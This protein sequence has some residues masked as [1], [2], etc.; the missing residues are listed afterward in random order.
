MVE[1]LEILNLAPQGLGTVYV[2][3]PSCGRAKK[4]SISR[5]EDGSILYHCFR[6]TCPANRGGNI[7]PNGVR[8][9]A[10]VTPTA[11]F[12]RRPFDGD[13]VPLPPKRRR[14]LKEVLGLDDEHLETARIMWA[15]KEARVAY[16]IFDPMGVRDGWCLR[17]YD[18]DKPKALTQMEVA[19][20]SHSYYGAGT[21]PTVIVEDPLSGIRASRYLN[22]VAL[23][24][25]G[26]GA[27]AAI[28]IAANRPD[29]IFAL[30]R[31]ATAQAI[32]LVRRHRLLFNSSTVLTLPRDL[33]DFPEPE[34]AEFLGAIIDRR[35]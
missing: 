6:P 19:R 11:E 25:A 17:S 9:L 15:P 18:G 16:P 29:V 24:G 20:P 33:K 31:D 7:T 26:L 22:A 30:D 13:I 35:T 27:S 23:L 14:Y 12:K 4:M 28:E 1:R 8:T 21:G 34:L 10:K 3:C 32:E 5:L 2:T